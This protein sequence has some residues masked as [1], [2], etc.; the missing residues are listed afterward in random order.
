MNSNPF[1]SQVPAFGS[2]GA[3]APFASPVPAFGAFGQTP[4]FHA[5]VFGPLKPRASLVVSVTPF[6]SS[7]MMNMRIA[8]LERQEKM[9]SDMEKMK[10]ELQELRAWRA[11]ME[12]LVVTI[13][14]KKRKADDSCESE[15]AA[16]SEDI[17]K[18]KQKQKR[19]CRS[20]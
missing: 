7:R 2:T 3:F 17:K 18:Q 5:P 11:Q 14:G 10:A 1:D 16:E 9:Q 19:Q 8:A 15:A 4:P 6:E 13:T 12:N 20:I